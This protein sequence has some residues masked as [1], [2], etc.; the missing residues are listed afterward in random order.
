MCVIVLFSYS[1][2]DDTL[3][4]DVSENSMKDDEPSKDVWTDPSKDFNKD[5]GVSEE[6]IPPLLQRD[7]PVN[8]Q[9]AQPG[10]Y[11]MNVAAPIYIMEGEDDGEFEPI[12][13]ELLSP[14][15]RA[16]AAPAV[17][18]EPVVL[19]AEVSAV[20][21]VTHHDVDGHDKSKQEGEKTGFCTRKRLVLGGVVVLVLVVVAVVIAMVA[22]GGGGGDD[23]DDADTRAMTLAPTVSPTRDPDFCVDRLRR[24][25]FPDFL[26]RGGKGDFS[27][28]FEVEICAGAEIEVNNP[29]GYTDPWFGINPPLIAQSN[30]HVKCGKE[31]KL[32]DKCIIHSG[33]ALM[34]NVYSNKAPGEKM[35]QDVLIEGLVFEKGAYNLLDLR[36][37][38][39]ITF[40]NCIFRVSSRDKRDRPTLCITH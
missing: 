10:A 20:K 3:K 26:D 27:K 22:G 12:P 30:M 2:P 38:G 14:H 39:N 17:P 7:A 23:G 13:E 8:R 34:M 32:T 25:F 40:K 6:T 33:S 21:L 15:R 35:V 9:A 16:A 11:A 37:A 29:V 31:G 18:E 24:D 28:V 36:G 1:T 4:V 5:G 19:D